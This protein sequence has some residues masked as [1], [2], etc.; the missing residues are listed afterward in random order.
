MAIAPNALLHNES[1]AM[2]LIEV[3]RL[4]EPRLGGCSIRCINIAEESG[5]HKPEAS[6]ALAD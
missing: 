4:H 1:L 3:E 2:L 6:T 5:A